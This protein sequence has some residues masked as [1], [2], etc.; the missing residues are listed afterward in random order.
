MNRK[1]SL[2]LCALIIGVIPV[3]SVS[4]GRAPILEG[5]SN[6]DAIDT[7]HVEMAVPSPVKKSREIVICVQ[8]KDVGGKGFSVRHKHYLE[9]EIDGT[10]HSVST[11]GIGWEETS[12]R[13]SPGS[14]QESELNLTSYNGRLPKGHYRLIKQIF[15]YDLNQYAIAEFDIE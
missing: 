1:I 14:Y 3:V 2:F 11:T 6:F 7:E 13:I 10:W 12:F 15:G 8:L 4:V 9:F 5:V